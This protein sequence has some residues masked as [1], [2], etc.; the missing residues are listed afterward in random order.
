MRP[1][2]RS[3]FSTSRGNF[4]SLQ[5]RTDHG[6]RQHRH[7]DIERPVLGLT[8]LGRGLPEYDLYDESIYDWLLQHS[9]Q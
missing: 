2:R 7:N 9:R 1:C 8:G 4:E 3:R 5:N 6:F